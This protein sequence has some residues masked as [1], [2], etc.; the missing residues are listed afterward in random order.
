[1]NSAGDDLRLYDAHCHL[2]DTRLSA[3][4]PHTFA[5]LAATGLR[6]AVV[7]G[8]QEKDWDRVLELA[9]TC[10][11]I[12]PSLG[13]HPWY[14]NER[15]PFWLEKLKSRV[16]SVRCGLGEIGLDRWIEGYDSAL[17][18]EILLQQLSLATALNRPVSIHCLKAWGRLLEILQ[19]KPLPPTGFLLHSYG[20][21]LEMVPQ[22]A[23]LGA[24]FSFSGYFAHARK[25]KQRE[26]FRH[27][28]IDRL[29]LETDAPDMLPPPELQEFPLA[30]GV[31]HPGNIRAIY[32]FAAEL[33]NMPVE[34]LAGRVELN[35]RRLFAP[36][37]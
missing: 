12:I 6:K 1:M 16:S 10:G 15:T 22:F 24:Y 23:K 17:Q 25:A 29:L 26:V 14:V 30:E 21:P 3:A 8:T 18:E 32:R 20:G 36:C 5:T 11:Q 7:N 31:N 13:L 37:F 28:P 35:F 2:Q 27:V 33:M 9:A 19:N 34:E 4:W